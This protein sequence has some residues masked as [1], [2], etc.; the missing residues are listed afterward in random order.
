MQLGLDKCVVQ[1]ELTMCWSIAQKAKMCEMRATR[2]LIEAIKIKR[3]R[4]VTFD[5]GK[6]EGEVRAD[7]SH[8]EMQVDGQGARKD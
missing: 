6:D 2:D 8:E 5:V 1:N 4:K 3:K 7:E